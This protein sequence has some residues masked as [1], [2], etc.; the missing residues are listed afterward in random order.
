MRKLLA[1]FASFAFVVMAH[2]AEPPNKHLTAIPGNTDI[3]GNLL[4]TGGTTMSVKSDGTTTTV[5]LGNL[6]AHGEVVMSDKGMKSAP[7]A[8]SYAS[9]P[10]FFN[11]ATVLMLNTTNEGWAGGMTAASVVKALAEHPD[12][13]SKAVRA[14]ATVNG[15]SVTFTF[16]SGRAETGKPLDCRPT[17]FVVQPV[18]GKGQPA[19]LDHAGWAP[20]NTDVGIGPHMVLAHNTKDFPATVFCYNS[21]GLIEPIT[22]AMRAELAQGINPPLGY[23]E[24]VQRVNKEQ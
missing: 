1:L 19:W 8:A 2:A 11:G 12:K 24:M 9:N 15:N 23:Q 21:R 16:P 14:K 17:N 20:S 22:A 10:A 4:P 6:A 3:D 13:A 18:A 5:T 7:L